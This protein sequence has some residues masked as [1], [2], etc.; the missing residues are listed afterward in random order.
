M[1]NFSSKHA[2]TKFTELATE[3]HLYKSLIEWLKAHRDRVHSLAV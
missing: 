1:P 3:P 2:P